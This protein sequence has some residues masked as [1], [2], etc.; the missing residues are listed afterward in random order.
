MR[1]IF[2]SMAA[3]AAMVGCAKEAPIANLETKEAI[4]IV[5]S[6][7]LS[8]TRVTV[9]GEK[10]TDVKWEQGDNVTL[11][12]AAGASA[13]LTAT[14]AGNENV[15]FEGEGTFAADTDTYYAIYPATAIEAGVATFD[16]TTQS[17]SDVAILAAKAENVAKGSIP[18]TFQPI[19]SLL[20]VA[21]SGVETLAK[22]EFMAYDGASVASGFSYDFANDTTTS[23]GSTTTLEVSNPAT[24]GFFFSLPA[25]LDMANGYVVRLTDGSGNVCS[26]A[27]N[28]KTFARG[29]TTRVDIAWSTPS[30][31]LGAKTSYSYYLL[32]QPAT[33]NSCANNV[34]YFTGDCATTYAGIQSA[35]ISEV[36]FVVDG[37][38]YSSN[39]GAVTWNKSS[40]SFSMSNLTVA[41][42]S[43]NVKAYIVTKEH[44]TIE[45]EST[46]Y[47]TGLPYTLNVSANDGSW[48]ESGYVTWNTSNSVRIG[49]NVGSIGNWANG[50]TTITK[51]DFSLPANVN[52]IVDGSF[53]SVGTGELRYVFGRPADSRNNTTFTLSI[54][55]SGV[56][57]YTTTNGNE[58][59][60]HS[61]S[62]KT[63][64]MSS[65]NAS[66]ELHNSYS[67]ASAASYVYSLFVGYGNK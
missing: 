65:S 39:D 12:S 44:G 57:S 5:A 43:H 31:T 33:A 25:D 60:T 8:E 37:T 66:I 9:E 20:H 26:K 52:V 32:N 45:S 2:M 55:G 51:S 53:M 21:V 46:L 59:Q 28:G 17:G 10:F 18:M 48:T 23:T 3:I 22:A 7:D 49:Y 13:T 61:C 63:A 14:A 67:T 42:G 24:A 4:S 16:L 19:N 27:Y 1:K 6:I 29:T 30:V 64:V 15:R 50:S 34:I 41:N 11:S 40:K 36:G 54:S 58:Q 35:F 56:H 62:N 38:T 47:I